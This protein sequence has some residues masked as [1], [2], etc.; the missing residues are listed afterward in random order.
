MSA[1]CRLTHRPTVGRLSADGQPTVGRVSV[2]GSVYCRPTVD[3]QGAKVHM[4]RVDCTPTHSRPTPQRWATQVASGWVSLLGSHSGRSGH[5]L[6][7]TTPKQS[8]PRGQHHGRVWLSELMPAETLNIK[9]F[10]CSLLLT[11]RLLN[12]TIWSVARCS[13]LT[14]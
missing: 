7:A 8:Q 6:K 2:D 4:I 5:R 11:G 10:K 13:R 9:V 12:D 1:D 14:L 3:R